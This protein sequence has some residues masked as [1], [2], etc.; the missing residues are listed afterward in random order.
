MIKEEKLTL[1]R[2]S[3]GTAGEHEKS[4]PRIPETSRRKSSRSKKTA[5]GVHKLLGLPVFT[6]D[7][8]LDPESSATPSTSVKKSK[9]PPSKKVED[10]VMKESEEAPKKPLKEIAEESAD[11]NL[12][13][14]DDS[15]SQ[16][17]YEN[18]EDEGDDPFR[19]GYIGGGG[20]HLSMSSTLRALTGYVSGV[21][22]R[23]RDILENLKNS[24]PSVQLIALQEL[25]EILLVSNEDNLSGHFAPESFVK[26]LVKL[27]QPNE[28]GEENTEMMLLACRCIANMM[29]ALPQS[30]GP[31]VY[32]GAVPIL[33]QKLVEIHFIDLAEQ[34]LS[35]SLS[36][37]IWF[38]IC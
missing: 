29:E 30:T 17:R 34:A 21:S 14:G 23:L 13:D 5:Q 15:I 37:Q 1:N 32:G 24:D 11:A 25:S 28:F 16:K 3:A 18:D 9:K 35:V 4:P 2:S 27:M 8:E 33:C 20:P 6:A 19:S 36:L 22:Q 31:V 38:R 10:I 7:C 12:S 26:Q